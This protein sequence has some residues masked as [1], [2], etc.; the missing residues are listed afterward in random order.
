MRSKWVTFST[1][2]S[3][4]SLVPFT[5]VQAFGGFI[6]RL[7]LF[8]PIVLAGIDISSSVG[9]HDIPVWYILLV[10]PVVETIVFQVIPIKV[11]LAL[12][13]PQWLQMA[14]STVLFALGH[15]SGGIGS[16][17]VATFGGIVLAWAFIKWSRK[18]I[19]RGALAAT[20]THCWTNL[21]SFVVSMLCI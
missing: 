3:E 9:I 20:L 5:M 8:L 11:A 7:L 1:W 21:A 4:L 15:L 16:V 13:A 17:L 2:L 18:S 10:G 6:V 19:V 12:H 14:I